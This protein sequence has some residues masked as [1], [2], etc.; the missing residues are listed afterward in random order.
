MR[1]A[2]AAGTL[3][4]ALLV[5]SGVASAGVAWCDLGSP[6]PMD[7]SLV[8]NPQNNPNGMPT[9]QYKNAN[10][11]FVSNPVVQGALLPSGVGKQVP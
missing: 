10:G 3:L 6:P 8:T 9:P 2:I 1:L 5:S 11:K 4:V 7:A